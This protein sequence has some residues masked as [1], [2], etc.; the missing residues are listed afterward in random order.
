MILN[1]NNTQ[2]LVGA[3]MI[4]AGTSLIKGIK[5]PD[6]TETKKAWIISFL[7]KPTDVGFPRK[8]GHR[9]YVIH[10]LVCLIFEVKRALII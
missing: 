2:V 6:Q 3:L 4:L 7:G 1:G 10:Y 8:N 5:A 9:I